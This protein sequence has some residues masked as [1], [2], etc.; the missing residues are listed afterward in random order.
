LKSH[1]L[2]NS[3]IVKIIDK[4]T[5][6]WHLELPKTKQLVLHEIDDETSLITGE[7]LAV[8]R[9]DK[10]F[11][12][13]L[14]ETGLLEKF[15]IVIVD[16]GAVK[17]VCNGANIM[18]PGIKNFTEFKKDDIICVTEDV[19]NKFLAVGKALLSSD[20]MKTLVKGEVIKNLHYISDKY[21]EIEKLIKK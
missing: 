16:S 8:I 13:F 5:D 14:S 12:P 4:I 2:S 9:V 11:L 10:I 6:Q 20:D 3:D 15:P 7:N 19:H 21:W 18:R 1:N 17:F